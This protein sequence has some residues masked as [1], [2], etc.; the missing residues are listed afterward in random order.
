[1]PSAD[2]KRIAKNTLFLYFRMGIIMLVKLYTSR[3]LLNV[4]GIDDYGVWSVVSA[5]V[6]SFSFI[7]GTLV[8][9]TQR[10]LNY[11]MGKG[12]N[13]LSTIFNTSLLLFCIV[14]C[15]VVI[16]LETFG[17]WFVNNHMNFEPERMSA[18]NW[19][20]QLS[21]VTLF[22]GIMRLPYESV[23]IAYERMSFYAVLCIVEAALLLGT[24]FALQLTGSYDR[25]ILYGIF[26][27]ISTFIILIGYIF[28]CRR[29]FSCTHYKF[30]IDKPLIK[31]MSIFSG[32]NFF[33]GLSSMTSNQGVNILLNI[34]FG[35]ALNAAYGIS[36]QIRGAV[37]V[38]VDNMHKAFNPQIIK[39]YSANNMQRVDFLMNT[40][41]KVSLLLAFALMFPIIFNIDFILKL[42][43]G[44]N[45]PPYTSQF[46]ILTLIQLLLVSCG[47]PI[48]TA[49]FAT[50][51]IKSFQLWLSGLIF[52]NVIFIYLFFKLGYEA[53]TAFYI[54][55]AVEV[56]I[57]IT[58]I[59]FMR[60]KLDFKIRPLLQNT[61]FPLTIVI[62]TIL[63][64]FYSIDRFLSLGDG[65]NRLITSL[66]IF[67]PLYACV[68]LLFG[69]SRNQ[70]KQLLCY[71]SQRFN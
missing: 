46:A 22:I 68:A 26:T 16:G 28:Y 24:A 8:S 37:S 41:I 54:K 1:M 15:I 43:L 33:G 71:I 27:L 30:I 53:V 48:D 12:G 65:I 62:T 66:A 70:R 7:N 63:I 47:T 18:V 34:F 42:W 64:V 6:I 60:V 45:I 50:G 4:L 67:I 2:N 13:K 57:L 49:I 11:D 19:I 20:Y 35:V 59:I 61:I 9:S 25:L 36:M 40:I 44:D 51:K 69:L 55:I 32:W 29:H 10:F 17:L 5:F 3:V 31:E 23:L 52:L 58:R 39:S 14:G 56:L 38:I 21:I